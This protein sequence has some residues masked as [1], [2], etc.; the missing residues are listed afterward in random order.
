MPATDRPKPNSF[1]E[2][3][4]PHAEQLADDLVS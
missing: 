2:K 3:I 1:N 4:L